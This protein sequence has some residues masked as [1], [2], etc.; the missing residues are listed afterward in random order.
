[1]TRRLAVLSSVFCIALGCAAPETPEPTAGAASTSSGMGGADVQPA[2]GDGKLDADEECDGSEFGD[3]SC[4][5]YDLPNG[6]LGCD[7]G[8]DRVHRALHRA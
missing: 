4:E 1:M 2:C 7:I 8:G 5:D 6:S 3:A